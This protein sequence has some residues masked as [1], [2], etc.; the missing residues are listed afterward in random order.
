MLYGV[1]YDF[2]SFTVA[3]T[4]VPYNCHKTRNPLSCYRLDTVRTVE[5]TWSS[6]SLHASLLSVHVASPVSTALMMG[7]AEEPDL[8]YV[9]PAETEQL[10]DKPLKF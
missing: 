6:S 8:I 10:P 5:P 2:N 1:T 9:D 7:V 3:T 4:Y